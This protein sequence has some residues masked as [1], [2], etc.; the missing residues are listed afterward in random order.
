ME[1]KPELLS[2]GDASLDVYLTPSESEALCNLDQKKCL[3]CF[4][5]GEKITVKTLDYSVGGNAANL[6]VGSKR[7]G[8]NVGLV[9][10]LGDDSIGRQIVEKLRKEAVDLT[11][12]IQ[13][14][15]TSSNYSTVVNYGGERTIFVYHAPRSYEFPV[16]LPDVGWIYLTSM[17]ESFT[18]FYKH[19]T[20]WIAKKDNI[21]LVFNPGSY[22]MKA[23]VEVLKNVLEKTYLIFVNRQ[24]AEKLAGFEESYGREK[25]LLKAVS[26]LGPKSVVITDG[27]NGSYAWDGERFFKATVLPIDP[28]ERTG[29]GDAFSTGA[30][31]ALIKAKSIKEALLWGTVNSAS[32]IGYTGP[33]KGLLREEDMVVWLDRAK[34]SQVEVGEF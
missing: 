7:L 10:T 25:E 34:S 22:Q 27:S 26:N 14:P 24:E 32:V 3:I 6:A 31:S 15:S 16:Q 30:L 19:F 12:V 2:I 5:Y 33:Q 11:Y 20:D 1:T 17:G 9:L 21:K 18:A 13:Q 8:I 23:G 4:S 29:A 28:Y